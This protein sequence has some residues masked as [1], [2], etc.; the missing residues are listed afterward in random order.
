M[1]PRNTLIILIVAELAGVLLL[2]ALYFL[3]RVPIVVTGPASTPI[4]AVSP[5]PHAIGGPTQSALAPTSAPPTTTLAVAPTLQATQAYTV[6]DGD[7]LWGIAVTYKLSLDEIVAA[8]PGINPDRVYPGDVINVPAPGTIDISQVTRQPTAPPEAAAAGITLRVKA[9]GDGLRLRKSPVVGDNVVTRLPALTLLTPVGRTTDSSW[10]QVTLSDGTSGWVMAQYVDI[11]GDLTQVSITDQAQAQQSSGSSGSTGSSTAN[12][13][14]RDEPYISG[15]TSKSA[16]IFKAG[17]ALGNRAGAFALVG[18][19]NTQNPAFLQALDQG[20]FNLGDYA[21]LQDT[22]QFFRG[23]FARSQSSPAAVGGFNTTKVLDPANSPG[24][25]NKG[26]T[27]LACEY[28][29]T[30]PSIALIL[31]G[32]GDQHTWQGFEGRYRTII[33]YTINQGIIPV[34]ITKGDD[35]EHRDNSAPS[36]YINDIIRRLSREYD[37]PLLDLR[38]AIDGLPNHGFNSDGFHYNTPPDG[39]SCYF[40]TDHMQYGYTI[41]NLTA[42]QILDALRRQVVG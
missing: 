1:R 17:Q 24:S 5:T 10:L 23:S 4:A 40:D 35:L 13:Q 3:F 30:K 7:T 41:R 22:V 20:N 25:C 18:D 28:R 16:S 37:V 29:I 9:E 31:M 14:P 21:Y 2:V 39:K 15:I 38:Q 27:P 42:L 33:E 12:L 36:G 6:V 8:N 11:T 32:T 19:S 26:E 34:L